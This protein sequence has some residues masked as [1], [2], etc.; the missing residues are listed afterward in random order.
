MPAREGDGHLFVV[1]GDLT[2]IACDAVLIPSDSWLNVTGNWRSLLPAEHLAASPYDEDWTTYVGPLSSSWPEGAGRVAESSHWLFIAAT[3]EQTARSVA[4]SVRRALTTVA[5]QVHAG[6]RRV[7]PLVALP[8]AGTGEGGLTHR[9]GEVVDELLPTLRDA[10]SD[11][12]IDV[13]LVLRDR[14][15][16]AA[17]QAGRDAPEFWQS[18]PKDLYDVADELG[19]R[20]A[21]RD[22]SLF[23]GAG[24]STPLGLPDWPQLVADLRTLAGL[25]SVFD[26]DLETAAQ[27]ALDELK[28]LLPTDLLERFVVTKCTLAHALLA[29]LE[30][31]QVVT[32][33]YD[34]A[35]EAAVEGLAP[36]S[37]TPALKVLTRMVVQPPLPWLLKLHGDA[38]TGRDIVL[39][40][41]QFARFAR[42]GNPLR[43]IVQTLLLTGHVLFIGSSLRDETFIRSARQVRTVLKTAE[44]S[45]GW[46]GT[47]VP[48]FRDEDLRVRCGKELLYRPMPYDADQDDSGARMLE[49]FLDRLAWTAAMARH[50]AWEYLMDPR[51][52]GVERLA[53]DDAVREL[54]QRMLDG[55]T[56]EV[57]S[58]KAWRVLADALQRLGADTG[59]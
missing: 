28:G 7:R 38:R 31:T 45:R 12:N 48:V 2:R 4:A 1:R 42:S 14:R 22:L 29:G 3:P 16:V 13:A 59:R 46:L 11:L 21:N 20:S 57:R 47:V 8:L 23:L 24:V 10:A 33:N 32:T 34:T 40:R 27:E 6:Q 18:L 39:T 5:K 26:A 51:Y 17:V 43:G 50:D 41:R 54:A 15:D 37:V 19:E 56:P 25:P 55:A 9:R 35:Y 30:L 58:S 53:E 44:E 52:A 49:I 36:D